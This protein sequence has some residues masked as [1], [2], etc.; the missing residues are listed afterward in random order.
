MGTQGLGWALRGR[1]SGAAQASSA[2]QPL[3]CAPADVGIWLEPLSSLLSSLSPAPE[4]RNVC[5]LG[6]DL[7]L[8]LVPRPAE[9]PG[10]SFLLWRCLWGRGSAR[11]GVPVSISG[12]FFLLFPHFLWV[13]WGAEVLLSVP[14]SRLGR[15]PISAYKPLQGRIS[16]GFCSWN[17]LGPEAG[18]TFLAG[19][20]KTG[21]TCPDSGW[22]QLG[23]RGTPGRAPAG[24]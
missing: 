1:C 5:D 12:F 4:L 21:E 3:P 11:P 22:D 7:Q 24:R 17:K 18:L 19:S 23:A 10:R 9:V 2:P 8:Q 6:A 14:Q 13:F 15:D 20:L 16:W